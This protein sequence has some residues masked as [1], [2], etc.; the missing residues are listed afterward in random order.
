L[1]RLFDYDS[2]MPS[3]EA[4]LL[5]LGE[6][7]TPLGYDTAM[8]ATY[9]R[10]VDVAINGVTD[11]QVGNVAQVQNNGRTHLEV[12]GLLNV[13]YLLTPIS[14]TLPGFVPV[15]Q[16]QS[17][18]KVLYTFKETDLIG[19]A[20]VSRG[21]QC[22]SSDN[23]ALDYIYNTGLPELKARAVLIVSDPSGM[24]VC[25]QGSAKQS[26][27]QLSEPKVHVRREADRVTVQ[28]EKSEGGILTLSDTYY[29]GWRVFVNGVEKPLLRTYTTLRAVLIGPGTQS[30]E[31]VYHP[32][33]FTR[34]FWLS[35]CTLVLLLL[36]VLWVFMLERGVI[37]VRYAASR[38][39]GKAS[40]VD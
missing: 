19:P 32:K 8:P 24:S 16:F 36:V 23:E 15:H 22:F 10:F 37:S 31:F 30:I 33:T 40:Q 17:K 21:V 6:L 28:V 11:D 25:N 35:N 2:V 34:L 20:F 18:D 26:H 4:P 1:T 38:L 5:A 14:M 3:Y 39:G 27:G 29:P 9:W 7:R 12:L 13:R